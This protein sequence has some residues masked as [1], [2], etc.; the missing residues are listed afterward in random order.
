MTERRTAIVT[1][2]NRGIGE[3]IAY[4]LASRGYDLLISH[5]G[6]ADLAAQVVEKVRRTY[7]RE[8]HSL[9]ID[10]HRPE[11][12]RKIADVAVEKLG[13]IDVLV[14]NAGRGCITRIQDANVDDIDSVYAVNFRA[15][16][17]LSKWIGEHMIASGT[18]GAIV[19]ITSVKAQRAYPDGS[20]YGGLKAALQ[21][22]SASLALE[23]APHGIRV[24]CVAPGTILLPKSSYMTAPR[25]TDT[26][27]DPRRVPLERYGTPEDIGRVVAFLIS[28]EASFCTGI[29][30]VVDGGMIL[31]AMYYGSDISSS[32][33]W[34]R[35]TV[36]R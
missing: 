3:G 13:K 18:H 7:R 19:N 31:P 36:V 27:P 4:V 30:I 32:N 29:S 17:L 28:E 15:P 5:R 8:A 10:A 24:N 2:G 6:E 16:L 33:P 12:V 34:G 11:D 26:A 35:S 20:I 25:A 21:Q 9:E 22:A 1:G 14:N 23:F